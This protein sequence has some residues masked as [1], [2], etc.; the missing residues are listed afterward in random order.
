M[1]KLFNFIVLLDLIKFNNIKESYEFSYYSYYFDERVFGSKTTFGKIAWKDSIH[2]EAIE[3]KSKINLW[4]WQ[5]KVL[6]KITKNKYLK[7]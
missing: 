1:R 2:Y 7:S 3:G 6:Y 4:N 5:A